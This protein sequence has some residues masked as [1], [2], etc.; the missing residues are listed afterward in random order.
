MTV[1]VYVVLV[2][3]MVV[4]PIFGDRQVVKVEEEEWSYV[5][6]GGPLPKARQTVTAFGAAANLVCWPDVLIP[7]L[8]VLH[9]MQCMVGTT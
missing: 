9:R 3:C 5:P 8:A 7:T 1:D 2:W 4:M 6:V